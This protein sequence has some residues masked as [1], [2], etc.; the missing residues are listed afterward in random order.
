MWA[1]ALSSRR[2]HLRRRAAAKLGERW[3]GP[4]R[5]VSAAFLFST[6]HPL[7]TAILY[8]VRR[9]LNGPSRRFSARAAALAQHKREHE[10]ALVQHDQALADLQVG[11][12]RIVA[13]Y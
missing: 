12:G 4:A 7:S 6:V 13:L 8:G 2:P 11:L 1:E 5:G 10:A 9:A 3:F